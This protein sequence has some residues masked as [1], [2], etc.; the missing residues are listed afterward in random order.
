MPA[1]RYPSRLGLTYEYL[2]RTA[3][4]ISLILYSA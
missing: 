4:A 1:I 2:S 3:R